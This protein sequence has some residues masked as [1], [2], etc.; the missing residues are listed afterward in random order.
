MKETT[1]LKL[2]LYK[3]NKSPTLKKELILEIKQGCGNKINE[4]GDCFYISSQGKLRLCSSCSKALKY[5]EM[6]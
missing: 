1:R 5:L 3:E 4:N 6:N 2:K